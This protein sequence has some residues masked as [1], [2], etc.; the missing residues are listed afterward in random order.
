MV[1]TNYEMKKNNTLKVFKA[2]KERGA[3][4]RREI[5]SVTG[6]SWGTVSAITNELLSR[7]FIV[8]QKESFG[9]GRPPSVL[10]FSETEYLLLGID[11]NSVGICFNVVNLG[12]K[13]V[14]SEFF[15]VVSRKK[16]D[17]LSLLEER[18]ENVLKTYEKILSVSVAMQGKI[19]R[20]KGVSERT[21]FFENWKDVPLVDFFKN[22][23]SLP[24]YLYHDPE[25][26][27]TFHVNE[28]QRIKDLKNGLVVRI[29][30]GIGMAQT[31]GNTLYETE[32]GGAC[33]LGH[34]VVVPNGEPCVC[35]KKGCLEA[36]SSLRG[37]KR[38]YVGDTNLDSDEMLRWLQ[39]NG[40]NALKIREQATSYLGMAIA[41][42]FTLF[43]PSFILIDGIVADKIDGFYD[44]IKEKTKEFLHA[45]D[46]PLFKARHKRDAAAIGACL[47]TIE[48]RLEE[49]IFPND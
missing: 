41:N 17:V 22:R 34:T 27:L 16:D 33:E 35:G 49:I 21:N 15:P 7:G 13:T 37:M 3:L 43:S 44:E 4:S 47:L 9:A 24:A 2:L 23:F 28:D 11:V 12:G 36:Y 6:L 5:E 26:L 18:A 40:E 32:T 48:K 25:C 19:D 46:C 1:Q 8:A 45:D 10:T 39:L 38:L 31:I 42:L 20:D 30:D 14:Y 29:D